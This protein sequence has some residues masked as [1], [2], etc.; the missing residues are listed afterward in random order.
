MH[1][2]N[3]SPEFEFGSGFAEKKYSKNKKSLVKIL[4]LIFIGSIIF[5]NSLG[6]DPG[7]NLG[8]NEKIYL[9]IQKRVLLVEIADTPAKRSTGLMY[10]K[11]LGKN[12]GMLF[13]YPEED[14][15]SFWMKNTFIPLSIGFFDKNGVLLETYDMRPNQTLETY[16]SRK[17]AIYALEVNQGWFRENGIAP[18]AVLILEKPV[19]GN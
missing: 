5:A 16:E 1:S 18:G 12:E 3:F 10:R 17:K 7:R 14:F 13:V 8:K 19:S 6:S 4:F 11:S 15:L 2:T 9:K